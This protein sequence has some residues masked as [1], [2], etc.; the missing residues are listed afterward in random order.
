MVTGPRRDT[1]GVGV[2]GRGAPAGVRGAQVRELAS[3]A[4]ADSVD[5]SAQLSNWIG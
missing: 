5:Q 2:G 4:S 1:G 3:L